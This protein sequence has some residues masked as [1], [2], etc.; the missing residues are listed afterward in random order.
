[1]YWRA[2]ARKNLIRFLTK[3]ITG[4]ETRNSGL[5]HENSFLIFRFFAFHDMQSTAA[6]G[7]MR[8]LFTGGTL[9]VETRLFTGIYPGLNEMRFIGGPQLSVGIAFSR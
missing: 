6:F 1:M 2:V 7:G 9:F 8:Q 5:N 4:Y 3:R